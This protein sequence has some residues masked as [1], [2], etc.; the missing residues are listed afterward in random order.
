MTITAMET[1][2]EYIFIV[3][4]GTEEN[5]LK[6]RF[7]KE[8]PEDQELITYFQNCKNE[9]ELLAQHEIEIKAPPQEI[10]LPN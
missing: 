1:V 3:T 7:V 2:T 10:Q 9:V 6:Y 5:S 4:Y 8:P